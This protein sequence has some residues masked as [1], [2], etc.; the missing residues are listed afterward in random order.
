MRAIAVKKFKDAPEMMD[1]PKPE[2]G[3]GEILVRL[4]AAGVNPFDVKIANG[5]LDGVMPHVFP[6]ILGIDGAGIV[7]KVGPGVT[8]FAVGDG[9]FG[10]FLHPP[11]GLGTYAEYITAPESIG[12]SKTPRGIYSSQAA[13]VPTAGM[14]A[15]LAIDQLALTKGQKL[16]ILGAAGGVGSFATQ[17]A[18]NLGIHVLAAAR[19]KQGEYLR[20][21]GAWEFF[22]L[23]SAS[24]MDDIGFSHPGGVDALLNLVH[25]GPEFERFLPALREGGVAAST[26]GAA[27]DAVLKPHNLRGLNLDLKPTSALLDRVAAEISTGRLRVLV[28]A[29]VPLAEAPS[30]LE[31]LR[32]GHLHGKLV[33][34]I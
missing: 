3:E 15:Q 26:I 28:D 33:L 17:M 5:A 11:V 34:Q 6:L 1:L 16:L 24:L 21:L 13:A 25:T 2:P 10:Q 31:R 18:A 27:D 4:G 7:E 23:E 32:G 29:Q 14:T 20:K 12:I 8:R 22:D 9:A 19:G 30:A